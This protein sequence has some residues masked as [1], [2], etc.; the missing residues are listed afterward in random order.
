MRLDA[1]DVVLRPRSPWEAVELGAALVRRHA[2]ALYRPWLAV[3]VPAFVVVNALA[4]WAQLLWLAPIVLWWLKP[5]FD[6]IP[7]YVLSRA[8]FGDVPGTR[9]TLRAQRGFGLRWL[10]GQ[11]TWRRL[12]PVRS[13]Y[14]PVDLLEGAAGDQAR[15]RRAALGGSSYGVAALLTLVF[16]HFEFALLL[17]AAGLVVL[18]VPEQYLQQSLARLG[19]LLLDAPAWL[20]LAYNALAWTATA[21]L[22]PFYVAGG[23]GLYLNR[24]TELEGWDIELALRRLRARLVA[25]APLLVLLV[26]ALPPRVHAQERPALAADAPRAAAPATL[27]PVFG[28]MQDDARLQRAVRA[29]RED[30][31]VSPTRKV[32]VWEKR[33]RDVREAPDA[34][35]PALGWLAALLGTTGRVLAWVLAA[36]LLLALLWTAPRWLAWMR[37]A[38]RRDRRAVTAQ[39]DAAH[40]VAVPL[41]DD[42]PAAARALWAAGRQR[43][44]LALVYRAAVA[45]LARRTGVELPPGATEAQC[46]RVARRL[47]DAA[48]RAAFAEAVEAWQAAAYAHRVPGT[49]AFEALLARLDARFAWST[50]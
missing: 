38:T 46:L 28:R 43:D 3:G 22:T 45:T 8:V 5:V 1:L 11:L 19:P 17:G 18:F 27:P 14:M 7:L 24:R 36:A 39:A 31:R 35:S 44:A 42:V 29:A 34:D 12:S 32:T 15:A 26:L 10:P 4:W 30:P 6:R 20:Q 16:V 40:R 21:V 23:F 33:E 49:D 9:E 25:G 50:R 41:P 47:E 2:R 37:G 48:D 13:L